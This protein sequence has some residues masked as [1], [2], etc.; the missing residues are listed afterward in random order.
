M[1]REGI[2]FRIVQVLSALWTTYQ[3][4]SKFEAYVSQVYDRKITIA[5]RFECLYIAECVKGDPSTGGL[6]SLLARSWKVDDNGVSI[7][8][9]QPPRTD[10]GSGF[11]VNPLIKFFVQGNVIVV[12][13]RLAPEFLCRKLGRLNI[14]D[15]SVDI[16]DLKVV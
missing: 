16:V 11:F 6:G 4:Q 1:E 5:P 3:Y 12:G 13:E 7:Q 2:S 9:L 15:S 14:S 8:P 10:N